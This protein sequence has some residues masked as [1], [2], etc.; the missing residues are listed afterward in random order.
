MID[1]LSLNI[2]VFTS[3]DPARPADSVPVALRQQQR[4]H[5]PPVPAGL[6]QHSPPGAGLGGQ[7]Q[8]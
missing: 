5:S 7:A 8:P 1:F 4:P 6:L 2:S 3:T